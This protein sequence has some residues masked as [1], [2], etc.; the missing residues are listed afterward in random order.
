M[1]QMISEYQRQTS[2]AGVTRVNRTFEIYG[3]Q[4]G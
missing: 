4:H 2:G 1:K 3:T